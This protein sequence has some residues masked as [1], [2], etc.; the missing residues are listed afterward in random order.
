MGRLSES[1][2]ETFAQPGLRLRHDRQRTL[3]RCAPRIV[4]ELSSESESVSACVNDNPL[5]YRRI[6]IHGMGQL[7]DHEKRMSINQQMHLLIQDHPGHRT[8]SL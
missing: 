2:D 6:K 4:E 3:T 1:P 5:G 8:R 7:G